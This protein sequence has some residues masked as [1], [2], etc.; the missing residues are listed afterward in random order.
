MGIEVTRDLAIIK[1]PPTIL[2]IGL[3]NT[4]EQY[5][6]TRHNLGF[7]VLDSF[8]A[9]HSLGQWKS[10]SSL[11][12]LIIEASI[13]SSKVILAKPTTLMNL[14]GRAAIKLQ[15]YFEVSTSNIL[16]IHD[17]IDID[18]GDIRTKQAGSSG[19]HNGLKSLDNLI[20]ED[21]WRIRVGIADEHRQNMDASDYVLKNIPRKQREQLP[22][23]FTRTEEIIT[24]F[25]ETQVL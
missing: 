5:S 24:K 2:I 20:G 12:S 9:K 22:A 6:N 19:G 15:D 3:G 7:L 10:K 21:Y 1:T 13:N 11:E 18:F 8:A 16:A 25:I 23:I 4:G 14:S 17:D